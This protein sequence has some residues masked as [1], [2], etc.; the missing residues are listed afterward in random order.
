M[1]I[2]VS[3]V[4]DDDSI[5]NYLVQLINES[6]QCTLAGAARNGAEA[7]AIIHQQR[8]DV[9][10]IDLGLP[11]LDGVE[12]ISLI[13]N[14]TPEARCMVVSTFGDAKHMDRSIRAGAVGYFLKDLPDP[15]IIEN[16]IT[17][18][19]GES[20]VTPSLLKLLFQ[21]IS[22]L[23]N[24][25]NKSAGFEQFGLGT[26]ELE[27]M[28]LLIEGLPIFDIGDRLC[29][30]THTVNQHLRAIYR[31]LDVHSRAKAVNIAIRHGL[32]EN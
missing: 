5:R 30:S 25:I 18:H 26:R 1:A 11:D 17:L 29:I 6:N 21:N 4:E 27:V 22:K 32:L 19:N 24:V 3:I 15:K 12:L 13:K 8:T 23:P 14:T 28:R 16:I 20:L 9:Y 2:A 31:K 10:L 7:K